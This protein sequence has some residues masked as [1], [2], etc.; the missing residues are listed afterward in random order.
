MPRK[1]REMETP[2]ELQYPNR[3]VCKTSV[4]TQ[5][6]IRPGYEFELH[7]RRW[8]AVKLAPMSRSS[9]N[10]AHDARVLCVAVERP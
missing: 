7:G 6:E 8:R 5:A 2:V 10:G 1:A 3:R 9:L 4:K